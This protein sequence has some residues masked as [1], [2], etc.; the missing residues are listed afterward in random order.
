MT[1]ACYLKLHKQ[2][3]NKEDITK[4]VAPITKVIAVNEQSIICASPTGVF[5]LSNDGNVEQGSEEDW[6]ATNL[7]W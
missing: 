2:I 5:D 4:Y 6:S 1:V 7:D 3:M